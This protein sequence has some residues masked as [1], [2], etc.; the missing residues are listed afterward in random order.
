MQ[1][2]FFI[3]FLLSLAF[4]AYAKSVRVKFILKT[5]EKYPTTN[6]CFIN[7]V[8]DVPLFP[9]RKGKVVQTY[10]NTINLKF[11]RLSIDK[12]EN[13]SELEFIGRILSKLTDGKSSGMKEIAEFPDMKSLFFMKMADDIEM[14]MIKHGYSVTHS[15]EEDK[16]TKRDSNWKKTVYFYKQD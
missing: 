2:I 7:F 14:L 12:T 10:E 3:I 5:S 6:M 13:K 15:I 4:N 9:A 1:K 11:T 16:T 8:S